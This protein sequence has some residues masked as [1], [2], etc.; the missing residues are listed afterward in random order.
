MSL[1]FEHSELVA[2]MQVD[3]ITQL[4]IFL[5]L[6]ATAWQLARQLASEF[7]VRDDLGAVN[8]CCF[9]ALCVLNPIYEVRQ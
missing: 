6:A 3:S 4:T 8:E 7:V 2:V 9:V 1:S 5:L